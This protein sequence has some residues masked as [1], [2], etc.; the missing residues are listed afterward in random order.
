MSTILLLE[1]DFSLIT[2]LSFALEKAG[3]ALDTAQT[4]HEADALWADGKYDL[5]ILDVSLPDGSGFAKI[6]ADA[7]KLSE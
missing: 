1:D 7:K 2:G 5:L 3:Y 4:L 6:D